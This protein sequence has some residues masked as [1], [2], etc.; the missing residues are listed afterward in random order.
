MSAADFFDAMYAQADGD[1]TAVPWQQAISRQ[2]I[3]DWIAEFDSARHHR[4]LVVAAGLGD[5]AA[6]LASRGLDVVAFDQAPTAVEWARK[7]HDGLTIDWQVA[8]LFDPPSAWVGGFDLVIEVFTIQS[9]PP[10][11]QAE[12]VTSI[13]AFLAD[14]GTLVAVA[15]VHDGTSE[16]QGPP[17][18]L[19]PSTFDLLTDGLDEHSHHTEAA[20]PTV[21]CHRVELRRG[22]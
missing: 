22:R 18:P 16:P 8:D 12:A 15:L 9:I 7:R 5:D 20:G 3:G 4:A 6:R 19:H 10:D 1:E 17:W 11:R 21:S 14:G 2:L 13:K